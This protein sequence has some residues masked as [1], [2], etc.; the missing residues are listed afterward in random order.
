MNYVSSNR[1]IEWRKIFSMWIVEGG[2]SFWWQ[3]RATCCCFHTA[4]RISLLF[5]QFS[6]FAINSSVHIITG[7]TFSILQYRRHWPAFG[8]RKP[9]EEMKL[10]LLLALIAFMNSAAIR[11]GDGVQTLGKD[12]FKSFVTDNKHVLVNFCELT[13]ERTLVFMFKFLHTN[14]PSNFSI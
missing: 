14:K 13:R 5:I 11:N 4:S 2:S 12:S 10:S 7:V 6:L 8:I 1:V 3:S 9:T